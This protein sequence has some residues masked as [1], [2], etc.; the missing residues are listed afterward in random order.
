[1]AGA[2]V[3]ARNSFIY[4]KKGNK[5]SYFFLREMK[6]KLKALNRKNII[7]IGMPGVGKSTVGVLL[8]KALSRDFLDTDVYIQAK[9]GR[10]LQEIIDQEGLRAFCQIEERHVRSLK[11]RSSIIATGGSVV[12]Y[13]AAM[14][15]LRS[16]GIV[17]HLDLALAP[18]KKRLTNLPTRGV[19]MAPGQRFDHLFDE[20]LPLYRKYSHLT[21]DCARRSHEEIVAEIIR[22]LRRWTPHPP[23]K[24][25]KKGMNKRSP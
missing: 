16:S 18:L 20:R 12:Y 9:E 15:H 22:R 25:M 5:R 11:F 17:I 4:N 7:L 1:L 10:T 8:A 3:Y 6:S 24:G 21:I 14:A 13:P 23:P 2:A 19:V